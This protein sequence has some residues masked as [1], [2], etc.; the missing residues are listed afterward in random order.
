VGKLLSPIEAARVLGLHQWHV[1]RLIRAGK[2]PGRR[3]AGAGPKSRIYIRSEDLE[4]ALVPIARVRELMD[5]AF[6]TLPS[7]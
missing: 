6:P 3:L 1:Y 4:Q 5:K 7:T 2:L